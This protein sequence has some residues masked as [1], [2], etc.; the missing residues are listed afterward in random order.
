MPVQTLDVISVNIWQILISLA[1]L[2]I[3]FLLLK[4]FLY[5]PVRKMVEAREEA[6]KDVYRRADEALDSANQDKAEYE[7]KLSTA[8]EECDELIRVAQQNARQ[9]SSAIITEAEDR[10]AGMIRRAENEIDLERSK[11]AAGMKQEIAEL[12]VQ[13][14]EKLLEREINAE[15]HRNLIDSFI[16]GI[17]SEGNGDGNVGDR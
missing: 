14:A 11:A 6:V 2:L 8:D 10:A 1:N 9:R 17:G 5:K 12:S 4:K 7:R 15:D 16:D 13:L 3:L